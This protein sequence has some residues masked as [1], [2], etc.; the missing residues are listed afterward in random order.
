MV[1]E[2][3]ADIF[4]NLSEGEADDDS[5][6]VDEDD[7]NF[8]GSISNMQGAPLPS[9]VQDYIK[10]NL[11]NVPKKP[12]INDRTSTKTGFTTTEQMRDFEFKKENLLE[13]MK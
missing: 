1:A 7:P 4:S 9:K 3:S 11:M 5:V 12:Y 10:N 2:P 8:T 6:I 13:L